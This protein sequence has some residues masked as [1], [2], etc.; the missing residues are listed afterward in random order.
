MSPIFKEASKAGVCVYIYINK[1]PI[2]PFVV[3]PHLQ[4]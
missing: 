2:N 4:F 1:T 3:M